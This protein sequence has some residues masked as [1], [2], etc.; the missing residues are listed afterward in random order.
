MAARRLLCNCNWLR[1]SVNWSDTMHKR[2]CATR[3]IHFTQRTAGR[4]LPN[5]FLMDSTAREMVI[6]MLLPIIMI[7]TSYKLAEVHGE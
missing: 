5:D 2:G 4:L 3:V 1:N 7:A 6:F